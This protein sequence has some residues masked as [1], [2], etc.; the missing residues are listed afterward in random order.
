MTHG[1]T[2]DRGKPWTID[3][4]AEHWGVSRRTVQRWISSGR[5]PATKLPDSHL[6]RI[7]QEDALAIGTEAA[8]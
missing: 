1:N 6:V 5:L 2:D 8:S 4:V 3:E 7:Q